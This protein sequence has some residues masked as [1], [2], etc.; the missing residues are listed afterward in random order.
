MAALGIFVY[1]ELKQRYK[2]LPLIGEKI[3]ILPPVALFLACLQSPDISIII[4]L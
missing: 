4:Y 1:V 3:N 2:R